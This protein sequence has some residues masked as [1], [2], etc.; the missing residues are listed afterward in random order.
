MAVYIFS[1]A[2]A[3]VYTFS[4]LS[5]HLNTFRGGKNIKT[6]KSQQYPIHISSFRLPL[7]MY[8]QHNPWQYK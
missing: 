6:Y 2:T 3:A 4:L 7:I 1:P 5:W 8:K